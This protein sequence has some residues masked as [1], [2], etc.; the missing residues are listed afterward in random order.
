MHRFSLSST[1][2]FASPYVRER[3][4]T[5]ASIHC[6][7]D[8]LEEA[9][10]YT[11]TARQVPRCASH[12]TL[13]RSSLLRDRYTKVAAQG[14]RATT[15]AAKPNQECPIPKATMQVLQEDIRPK[16]S[17]RRLYQFYNRQVFSLGRDVAA[18][19]RPQHQDN[20][21]GDQ[22]PLDAKESL[23]DDDSDANDDDLEE[24]N[25]EADPKTDEIYDKCFE[26]DWAASQVDKVVKDAVECRRI[27]ELLKPH[28]RILV[29]LFRAYATSSSANEPFR[30]SNKTKLLDELSVVVSEPSR[31]GI[32]DHPIHRHGMI[33]F[34]AVLAQAYLKREELVM[35]LKRV[36]KEGLDISLAVRHLL[37]D[38]IVPYANIQDGNHF[39]RIFFDHPDVQ[40]V[41]FKYI[42][43]IT[44]V[45]NAHATT[46]R[47]NAFSSTTTES[48]EVMRLLKFGNFLA[49]I[50]TLTQM[51][52]K[53]DVAKVNHIFVS[54]LPIWPDELAPI[55]QELTLSGFQEALVK[56]AFV[57]FEKK[58][59]KAGEDS[60]PAS[61]TSERCRCDPRIAN[62]KYKYSVQAL[63]EGLE[64]ILS[65]CGA[66]AA[67]RNRRQS[68]KLDSIP[69]FLQ[70]NQN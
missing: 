17:S 38:N 62:D 45:F 40:S 22:G 20:M 63:V 21:A 19:D 6:M 57:K 32:N 51:D 65:K 14:A 59:C 29:H 49:I 36:A 18:F 39:R 53:L 4:P 69:K 64:M 58:V 50:P 68:V 26:V 12:P 16:M 11:P 37:Y 43:G 5:S 31:H 70:A 56:V 1:Q 66:P 28:Y 24:S 41:M 2:A 10:V 27:Q 47:S 8:E 52:A 7:L 25:L 42:V 30:F 33:S 35:L 46:S 15:R 13:S 48:G 60:C 23:Q 9:Y 3:T 54:C 55:A 61:S 67:R 34:V 44:K